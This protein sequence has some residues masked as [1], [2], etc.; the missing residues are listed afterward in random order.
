LGLLLSALWVGDMDEL[1]HGAPAAG[2]ALP[3]NVGSV[4]L[5]ANGGG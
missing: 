2:A 4:A 1:L 5:T 3:A